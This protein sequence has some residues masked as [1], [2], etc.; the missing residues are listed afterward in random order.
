MKKQ[1]IFIFALFVLMFVLPVHFAVAQNEQPFQM[2]SFR[3][4]NGMEVILIPNHRAPLVTQLIV[5]RV[6]AADEQPSKTGLAHFLEHLMFKGTEKIPEGDFSQRIQALGGFDNA[7]TTQDYTAYFQTVPREFLAVI[8]EMESDRMTGLVLQE[9]KIE[10]ERQV[11]LEER[12]ERVDNSPFSRYAER[13]RTVLYRNHPYHNPV[14]GWEDDI[15]GLSK[16]DIRDFYQKWYHPAQAVLILA[17]DVSR[18]EAELLAERFY[19]TITAREPVERKRPDV[20]LDRREAGFDTKMDF[21]DAQIRQYF[22]RHY[23]LAPSD[24]RDPRMAAALT[25]MAEILDGGLSAKMH[26]HFVVNEKHAVSANAS[27][28]GGAKDYGMLAFSYSM[29]E[30]KDMRVH[31]QAFINNL[32]ETG[33]AEDEIEQAKR[34]ILISLAFARDDVSS[35]ARAVAAIIGVGGTVDELQSWPDLLSSITTDEVNKAMVALLGADSQYP[36]L[37]GTLRPLPLQAEQVSE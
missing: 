35:L 6:G 32:L 27:Y 37:H 20:A 31:H 12:R 34:R 4:K 2:E 16:Q 11:I 3:L 19:G 10:K 26:Q 28:S 8:M 23:H 21:D 5:Y 9:D 24:G 7:Y 1:S 33:F 15:R 14:I 18:R 17:G 22:Y 29:D 25:I 30:D 13:M 36:R